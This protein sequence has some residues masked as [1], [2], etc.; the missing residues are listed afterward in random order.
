MTAVEPDARDGAV[1]YRLSGGADQARFLIDPETGALTFAG[2]PDY[3]NP[4]DSAG[5]NEYIVTVRA[6]SGAGER[7]RNAGQ[8]IT[9]TVT[10]VDEAL[11]KPGEAV[12]EGGVYQL[13]RGARSPLQLRLRLPR[14]RQCR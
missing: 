9:V 14:L 13:G 12:T 4:D 1:R 8:T 11:L 6:T 2:L 3:E 5:N 10:D 7:E